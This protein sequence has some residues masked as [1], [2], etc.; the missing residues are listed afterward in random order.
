MEGARV[1]RCLLEMLRCVFQLRCM[2]SA[3]PQAQVSSAA[4]LSQPWSGAV[5]AQ[6][7]SALSVLA[8]RKL[9]LHDCVL[10]GSGGAMEGL[11]LLL[12]PC[13]SSR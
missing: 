2:L 12:G 8:L 10:P 7:Q 9:R 11:P 6:L 1:S 13:R 4:I 3:P 5:A